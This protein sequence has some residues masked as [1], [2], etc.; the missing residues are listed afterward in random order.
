MNFG[1]T[2]ITAAV[3]AGFIL[4]G[5]GPKQMVKPSDNKAEPAAAVKSSGKSTDAVSR[6]ETVR[7]ETASEKV[8][9]S[10]KT[11]DASA[12]DSEGVRGES[13]RE[14][15]SRDT[16]ANS[17][18]ASASAS[19]IIRKASSRKVSHGQKTRTTTA[20]P[21]ESSAVSP[22]TPSS[23]T[24]PAKA[25]RGNGIIVV[26]GIFVVAGIVYGLMHRR[27]PGGNL[28]PSGG[29]GQGGSRSAFMSA[30]APQGSIN[31]TATGPPGPPG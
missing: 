4:D 23:A 24:V 11:R 5:C 6:D 10:G 13:A 2:W 25:G 19:P 26:V 15:A 1:K 12:A 16:A 20:A 29:S 3:L 8:S 17:G 22:I 27:G 18:S 7:G 30:G 21:A 9:R 31:S 14:E 28:P